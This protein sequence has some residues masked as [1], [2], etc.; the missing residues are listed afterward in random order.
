MHATAE[1]ATIAGGDEFFTVSPAAGT[2]LRVESASSNRTLT[3]PD[4]SVSAP[5]A[6]HGMAV[7]K[8]DTVDYAVDT[9]RD[10]V[11]VHS[12]LNSESASERQTYRFENVDWI[13]VDEQTGAAILF[14]IDAD[15]AHPVGGVDTPWAVD[16]DGRRVPTRFETSADGNT[17]IQVVEHHV[18]G[19][20][21][22]ITADPKWWDNVASWFQHSGRA[23]SDKARSAARWLGQAKS[24]WLKGKTW[25]V[26][27]KAGRGAKVVAKKIGPAGLALCAVGAGWAWY[28]SD[29]QG[30]VRVGDAVSGCLL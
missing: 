25:S 19:F 27:R 4:P 10:A 26:A 21:Y 16:A 14:R 7:A 18:G 29:A 11:M 20:S 28:R 24:R 2:G 13:M 22:P 17:L 1:P 8:G 23:A 12:I 3:I 30:W 9:S 5:W 15:G 6:R